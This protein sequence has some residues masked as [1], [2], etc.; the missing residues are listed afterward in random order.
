MAF[1]VKTGKSAPKGVPSPPSRPSFALGTRPPDLRSQP[2]QRVKPMAGQTQ[3]GKTQ[4]FPPNV[5]GAGPGDTGRS[6]MT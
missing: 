1:S 4:G 3:Y 2:I 5:G 6:G